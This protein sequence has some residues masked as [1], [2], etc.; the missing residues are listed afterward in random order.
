MGELGAFLSRG[1]SMS[2]LSKILP[3]KLE[4]AQKNFYMCGHIVHP[5][6]NHKDFSETFKKHKGHLQGSFIYPEGVSFELNL[7]ECFLDQGV[8]A[9][10]CTTAS[11]HTL[12]VQ[13]DGF[14]A[15]R[16]ILKQ[17]LN[18]T[19]PSG[20]DPEPGRVFLLTSVLSA[21]ALLVKFYPSIML[22]R[23]EHTHLA[24]NLSHPPAN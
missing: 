3:L 20:I 2:S 22:I 8:A 15:F 9:P 6:H 17:S 13:H 14:G 19:D 11:Q 1:I 24:W 10:R 16:T 5:Y 4:A 18:D 12:D 7:G 23:I 21:R